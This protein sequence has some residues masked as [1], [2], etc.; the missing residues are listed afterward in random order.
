MFRLHC[1]SFVYK[2][3]AEEIY[4]PQFNISLPSAFEFI[5]G[6]VMGGSVQRSRSNICVVNNDN[7]GNI[8]A[9]CTCW[10]QSVIIYGIHEL[11]VISRAFSW[12]SSIPDWKF[13]IDS[14]P[15][16]QIPSSSNPDQ[17]LKHTEPLILG[18]CGPF[19]RVCSCWNMKLI[20][21]PHAYDKLQPQL[22]CVGTSPL[23]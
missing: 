23:T 17:L 22:P 12:M 19:P 9:C 5:G 6:H 11:P 7:N 15:K 18:G 3:P 14:R 8:D 1:L 21:H 20:I 13:E 10:N 16:K 2:I 4:G